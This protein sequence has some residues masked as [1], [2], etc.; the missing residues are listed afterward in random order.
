MSPCRTTSPTLPSGM[1]LRVVLI[2]SM[3]PLHRRA[4]DAHVLN[5]YFKARERA[6]LVVVGEYPP[7]G[8]R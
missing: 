6:R 4:G 7:D 5:F 1:S 2:Q 3:L 8:K